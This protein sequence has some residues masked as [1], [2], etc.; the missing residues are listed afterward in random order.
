MRRHFRAVALV[1]LGFAVPAGFAADPQKASLQVVTQQFQQS[2][3]LLIASAQGF[4]A[5]MNEVEQNGKID[6]LAFKRKEINGGDI[7]LIQILTPAELKILTDS[8]SAIS[9]YSVDLASL[10]AG[11]SLKTFGTNMQTFSKNMKQVGTDLG[12]ANVPATSV[13]KNKDFPGAVSV[14]VTGIGAIAALIEGRKAQA[15][16]R[17]E[18]RDQDA[19]ISKL[20]EKIATITEEAY[21]RQQAQDSARKRNLLIEYNKQI[22]GSNA[23][24]PWLIA[25]QL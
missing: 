5:K 21:L 16:V 10:A 25:Q 3:A 12:S 9:Q 18:I 11:S 24:V 4:F 19:A 23:F 13:L 15:L 1:A 14:I 22:H 7:D 17:K 6:E 8:M 2:P 20:L